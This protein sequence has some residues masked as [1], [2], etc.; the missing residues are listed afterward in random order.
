MAGPE[1][2]M[3]LRWCALWKQKKPTQ[4]SF[5]AAGKP[6]FLSL[7]LLQIA[8]QSLILHSFFLAV[9]DR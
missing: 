4:Q 9:T 6:A 3:A 1:E 2:A 5:L 8:E 7:V